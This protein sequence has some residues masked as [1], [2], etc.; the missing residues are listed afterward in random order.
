MGFMEVYKNSS[1]TYQ[2]G[3]YMEL[4]Q[5]IIDTYNNFESRFDKE[6]IHD[7]FDIIYN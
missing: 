6:I 5:N 4:K 1:M 7:L 2:I 3:D